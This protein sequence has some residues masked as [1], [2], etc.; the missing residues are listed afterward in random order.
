MG[1]GAG[2]GGGDGLGRPS[3]GRRAALWGELEGT[4]RA[5]VGG[6]GGRITG[7]AGLLDRGGSPRAELIDQRGESVL[8][9]LQ[10]TIADAERMLD[11]G[12]GR[13]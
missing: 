2:W 13:L 11:A 4:G 1:G 5:G 12:E 9:K 8:A 3:G 7:L 10:Q 6:V